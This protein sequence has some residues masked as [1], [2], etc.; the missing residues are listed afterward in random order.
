MA[1]EK[2][3]KTHEIKFQTCINGA[4]LTRFVEN[5]SDKDW[6]TICDIE[7]EFELYGDEGR[8]IGYICYD[9]SLSVYKPTK[10]KI[11]FQDMINKFYEAYKLDKNKNLIVLF[12]D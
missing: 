1:E 8:E 5:N 10:N 9:K 3:L 7:K 6:N 2:K 4:E 11:F 12:T